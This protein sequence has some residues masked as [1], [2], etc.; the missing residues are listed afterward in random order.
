MMFSLLQ[1]AQRA[2]SSMVSCWRY[3]LNRIRKINGSESKWVMSYEL[4]AFLS[5]QNFSANLVA[6]WSLE[7]VK[8]F[9]DLLNF[10]VAQKLKVKYCA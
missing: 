6:F 2:K 5:A 1:W 8:K 4:I 7:G 3:A 10:F 9:D